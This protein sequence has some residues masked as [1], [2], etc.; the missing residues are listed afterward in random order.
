MNRLV[1]LFALTMLFAATTAICAQDPTVQSACDVNPGHVR[2][3]DRPATA[4]D[5]F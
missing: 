5:S 3:T 1:S 2:G 4:G